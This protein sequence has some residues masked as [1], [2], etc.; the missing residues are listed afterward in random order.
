MSNSI[1]FVLFYLWLFEP[2]VIIVWPFFE[3]RKLEIENILGDL[4]KA[5]DILSEHE[6]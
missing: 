6:I 3:I 5:F 2:V 4:L 1:I